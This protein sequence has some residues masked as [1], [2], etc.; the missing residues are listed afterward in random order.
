MTASGQVRRL[1][2]VLALILFVTEGV[3]AARLFAEKVKLIV[4]F[5]PN[6]LPDDLPD[7]PDRVP[8][9]ARSKRF[10][11]LG[12]EVVEV[13]DSDKQT[14]KNKLK[15]LGK[16][17]S[18]EDDFEVS[19]AGIPNDEGYSRLWGMAKIGMP[20]A[21]ETSTGSRD[22]VVC[23]IDT[24]V[25]YNHP[26][27]AA[28]MWTNPNEIPGNGI[29]DDNNGYIDD[30]YGI[31]PANGDS[32][33]MDD[34]DHGTHC[35][36]GCTIECCLI[37]VCCKIKLC[38]AKK[39]WWMDWLAAGTIGG[40][41][42]NNIGVVGV[43][44][45]VSIMAFP[46]TSLAQRNSARAPRASQG[47]FLTASGSGSISAALECLNYALMMG[48]D[49]TS[50]SWGGGGYSTS[51]NSALNAAQSAGQLFVAAAGNSGTNNDAS[52]S[53]PSGYAFLPTP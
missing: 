48:A 47:K 16:V 44:H 13:K 14:A 1:T 35:A 18:V 39:W 41:G 38:V 53:Y 31:D 22:T 5:D 21:W 10:G 7:L 29:D 4:T 12:V 17:L 46:V 20:D 2:G 49:V 34:N 27:L 8:E 28:N 6:E 40:V 24:G 9:I 19:I 33:P 43:N 23:V 42:N 30:V 37:W 45:Q 52:A 36:G 32:N 51:F 11:R 15:K 26:D 25:D 3:F 50:N